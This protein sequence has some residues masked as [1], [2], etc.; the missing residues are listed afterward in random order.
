MLVCMNED[1]ELVDTVRAIYFIYDA[2]RQLTASTIANFFRHAG[3]SSGVQPSNMLDL[4]ECDS[5]D[6]ATEKQGLLKKYVQE[7]YTH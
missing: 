2:W 3:F 5:E 6:N 1:K 4:P 7:V